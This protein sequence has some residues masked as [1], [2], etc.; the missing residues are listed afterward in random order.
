M[1]I[2]LPPGALGY[3]KGHQH[4]IV[5]VLLAT[6]GLSALA[7]GASTFGTVVVI[8]GLG[9]LYHFRCEGSEKHRERLTQAEVERAALKVE[10]VRARHQDLIENEQPPLPLVQRPRRRVTRD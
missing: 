5:F 8:L 6:G 1:P 4:G 3:L 7:L 9:G 10:N 2:W